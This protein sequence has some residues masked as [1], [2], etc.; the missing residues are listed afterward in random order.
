M[1]E[2]WNNT[3]DRITSDQS[4]LITRL[5]TIEFKRRSHSTTI[6][7]WS[8]VRQVL[9]DA[10]AASTLQECV[11]TLHTCV[12]DHTTSTQT[13]ASDAPP[14]QHLLHL[15]DARQGLLKRWR[16]NKSNRR[17]RAR[18]NRLNEEIADYSD[19]LTR[20]SWLHTCDRLD[21]TMHLG[22]AWRLLRSLLNPAATR[23]SSQNALRM[24]L[25]SY[26]TAEALY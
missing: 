16:C 10:P 13:N 8:R 15:L 20:E 14:D 23:T 18:I 9:Q 7:N 19:T 25:D 6:T 2:T 5:H 1:T 4:L 24:I 11:D 3:H 22:S 21:S 26:D 17:L 12:H